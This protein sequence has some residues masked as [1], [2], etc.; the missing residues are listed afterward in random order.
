[1]GLWEILNPFYPLQG[2]LQFEAVS[3]L[4]CL[5]LW[6]ISFGG[7]VAS[8][9]AMDRNLERS[10]SFNSNASDTNQHKSAADS[11]EKT[12]SPDTKL[13]SSPTSVSQLLKRFLREEILFKHFE[14]FLIKEFSIENAYFWKAVEGYLASARE[15]KFV[16]D[17]TKQ[18][19][20]VERIYRKFCDPESNLAVNISGDNRKMITQL[21][22]ELQ[23]SKDDKLDSLKLVE[24][25]E[26]L[27]KARDEVLQLMA[28]DT[29]RR[30]RISDEFKELK[31]LLKQENPLTEQ[32]IPSTE[33]V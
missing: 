4:S 9:K 28:V 6:R 31:D 7:V 16:E 30:F 22:H 27:C 26:V 18:K 17:Q 1:M 3:C 14:K 32:E 24:A 23:E 15:G 12:A 5:A 11:S 10:G 8:V 33:Q 2:L 25:T 29:F 13:L 21:V 20:V 19:N